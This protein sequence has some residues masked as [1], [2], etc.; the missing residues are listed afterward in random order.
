M[1]KIKLKTLENYDFEY[2]RILQ[3]R[4]INYGGHLSND[5]VATLLHEARIDLFNKLG[6]SELDLGDKKTGI[7]MTD[8]IINYKS[9]GY[10]LDKVKVFTKFDEITDIGFRIIHKITSYDRIIA[11]AE[12]GIVAYNYQEKH[13]AEIPESFLKKIKKS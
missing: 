1:P 3:V 10:L 6:N 2:E 5:A 8:L 7:I 12:V 11:L 4:D 9:E 13:I